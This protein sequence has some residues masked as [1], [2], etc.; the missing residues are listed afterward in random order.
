MNTCIDNNVRIYL[1]EFN[2]ILRTMIYRMMK[3]TPVNSVS[4][5]FILQMIPHHRAAI[6]MSK[7]VLL[8]T[9]DKQIISIARNIISEQTKSIS[10]MEHVLHCCS[11]YKNSDC[12]IMQYQTEFLKIATEMY[13]K[14][15]HAK[16]S[17]QI[18]LN[19][20]NEMIPHHEGAISMSMNTLNYDICPALKPILDAIIVSQRRG[21]KEME[22]LLHSFC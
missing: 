5:N 15:A 1:N 20:L 17:L 2:C 16:T 13:D 22:S 10:D 4:Q 11:C 18:N 6:E 7:N 9:T 12:D 21:V 19:F 8:Y 3:V 14:M